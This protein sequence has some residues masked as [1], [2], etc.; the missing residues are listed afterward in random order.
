MKSKKKFDRDRRFKD[1]R[2]RWFLDS[3]YFVRYHQVASAY[4]NGEVGSDDWWAIMEQLAG[5]EKVRTPTLWDTEDAPNGWIRAGIG[6]DGKPRWKRAPLPTK[7]QIA[8]DS[9]Y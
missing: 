6:K 3:G 7:A 1:N 5:S 8:K 9:V 2:D 4:T